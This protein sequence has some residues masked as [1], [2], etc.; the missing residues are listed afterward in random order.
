MIR[1]NPHLHVRVACA[2]WVFSVFTVDDIR[3]SVP[4]E[5]GGISP[6]RHQWGAIVRARGTSMPP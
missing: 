6:C 1:Y 4:I 2:F 3:T 5:T